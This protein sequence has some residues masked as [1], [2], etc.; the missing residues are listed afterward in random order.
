LNAHSC[1]SLVRDPYLRWHSCKG[2]IQHLANGVR[3]NSGMSRH[4]NTG[5]D[6][7]QCLHSRVARNSCHRWAASGYTHSASHGARPTAA[8][9][10]RH[11]ETGTGSAGE[12][13]P[14]RSSNTS[15]EACIDARTPQGRNHRLDP[16]TPPR[17]DTDV[18][19]GVL[20]NNAA[21]GCV[22]GLVAW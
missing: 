19:I 9:P 2:R 5:P 8:Y 17:V 11:P 21:L 14:A 15:R 22:S 12:D 18:S 10:A 20:S 13:C 1:T 16:D 4:E 6:G 7:H 3:A